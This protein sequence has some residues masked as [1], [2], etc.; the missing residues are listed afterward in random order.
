MAELYPL[1]AQVA[2]PLVGSGFLSITELST[3]I[4]FALIAIALVAIKVVYWNKFGIHNFRNIFMRITL[5]VLINVFTV[6]AI[7]IG[8]NRMGDFYASWND[9][10][11][12]GRDL[13]NEAISPQNLASLNKI[14]VKRAE[15]SKNGSLIFR[16][17]ITGEKSGVSSNVIV[18]FSPSVVNNLKKSKDFKIGENYQVIELFPGYPGVP[19]TWIGAMKGLDALEKMDKEKK[20]PPTILI[21]PSINVIPGLDTEC[22]NIP[23]EVDVETWLTSDMKTFATKFIGLDDRKWATFGYSTGGWCAAELGIRHQDQ[24]DRAVSLA[25]YFSPAFSA[26]VTSSE[27]KKL[28]EEY[29]LVKT[30]KSQPNSLKMLAIFSSQNDFE[31]KSLINFQSKIGDALSLKTI[32]I[33]EG[34]HNIKVWR[35]YVYTGFEWI[36]NSN[37]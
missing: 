31:T 34:G 8:L 36:S 32:E 20:I 13:K 21:I 23:G 22:L 24:F 26:G 19:S 33:P 15:K 16:K 9:L 12:I 25:G 6:A 7:G 29:D 11:G 3:E 27:R 17:V 28:I 14:D 5:I 1:L 37:S 4:F 2:F 30:I 10:F 35:P 18:V